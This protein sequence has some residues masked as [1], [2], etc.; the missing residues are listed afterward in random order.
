M[1]MP[2]E[3]LFS[4]TGDVGDDKQTWLL[5]DNLELNVKL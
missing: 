5:A 2:R 1:S 4:S 3:R